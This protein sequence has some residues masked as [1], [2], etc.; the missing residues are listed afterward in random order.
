MSFAQLK[1]ASSSNFQSL[2]D[3]IDKLASPNSGFEQDSR[4]WQPTVDEAGN[5][6]AIIR[7]L[8]APDGEE[9]PFVRIQSYS[10]KGPNGWYIEN[11]R[12]TLH[13]EEGDPV[14]EHVQP[15]WNSGSKEDAAEAR[16]FGKRTS[17]HSNIYIVNDPGNPANNGKVFLYSYGKKIFDKIKDAMNPQFD[18]E[19]PVDPFHLWE[20][21]NFRLKIRKVEGYRNYDKSEF[22]SPSQLLEDEDEMEKIYNSEYSLQELVDPKNFK[23]YDELK[24]RFEKVMGI[25]SKTEERRQEIRSE[26]K[27]EDPP[28]LKEEKAPKQEAKKSVVEDDDDEE[29]FFKSLIDD[30]DD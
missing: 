25:S 4:Y 10:F 11:S 15:L 24:A 5:G 21:A 26:L 23:S 2:K 13:R 16:K 27:E 30:D 12:K 19:K 29:D 7:F 3:K 17:F 14:A 6:Y 22:D 28:F 9:D 8:P 20:G 1:K 18:D